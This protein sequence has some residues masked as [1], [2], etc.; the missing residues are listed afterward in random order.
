M[1]PLCGYRP[2]GAIIRISSA[3]H[4]VRV[5]SRGMAKGPLAERNPALPEPETPDVAVDHNHHHRADDRPGLRRL[6]F[7]LTL[8]CADCAAMAQRGADC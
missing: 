5:L 1:G 6:H 4:Q 2:G 7:C 3:N 8:S